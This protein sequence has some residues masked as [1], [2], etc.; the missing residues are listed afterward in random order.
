MY[1]L[2]THI[3]NI[4]NFLE[5]ATFS[6]FTIFVEGR[7]ISWNASILYA[8]FA[9]LQRAFNSSLFIFSLSIGCLLSASEWLR[10][11]VSFSVGCLPSFTFMFGGR[12]EQKR[13]FSLVALA[14]RFVSMYLDLIFFFAFGSLCVCMLNICETSILWSFSL[15]STGIRDL[16]GKEIK[17]ELLSYAM[18]N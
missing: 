17:M 7:V 11:C 9:L 18:P 6:V 2:I 14:L 10:V 16:L 1:A 5:F 15:S 3:N 8:V 4:P 13:T 12:C